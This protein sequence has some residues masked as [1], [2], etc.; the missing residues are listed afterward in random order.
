MMRHLSMWLLEKLQQQQKK[1][2]VKQIEVILQTEFTCT[3]WR[4]VQTPKPL[5]SVMENLNA[6]KIFQTI[7]HF[8]HCS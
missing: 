2:D 8:Q 3:T 1:Q 6:T 5:S 4:K 7:A